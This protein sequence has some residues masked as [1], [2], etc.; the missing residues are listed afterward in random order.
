MSAPAPLPAAPRGRGF[1]RSWALLALFA[2]ASV[3]FASAADLPWPLV[4]AVLAA[5]VGGTAVLREGP[6]RG[7]SPLSL[8]PAV[9]MLALLAVTAPSTAAGD[10]F[11]AL[12]G[13]ALLAWLAEDSRR[14]PGGAG[15]AGPGLLLIVL[16]VG[17][18]WASAFL[19][20][21]G[22]SLVGVG[23]ALLVLATILLA[24]LIARPE[25]I[26]REPAA[27]A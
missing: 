8:V 7:R 1:P 27:T 9:A 15:R 3:L 14:T 21:P 10:L 25:L 4:L 24:Y 26:D 13:V 20:P 17:I 22:A 16:T 6:R 19:L 18:A 11:G 12:A 5:G 23:A 2:G